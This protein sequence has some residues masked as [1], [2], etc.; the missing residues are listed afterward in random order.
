LYKLSP[1]DFAYIYEEC[2][3]CFYLKIKE[4]IS[5]PSTPFPGVF[6]ALNTRIQGSLLR[7]NLKKLSR[8]LPDCEVVNQEGFVESVVI[9]GTS[10]YIKG[11]YD[12]LCKNPDSTYTLVDL[13]ISIPDEEKI[14][15]YKTQ[16][17]AYKF[18]M[19]NPA[20]EKPIKITR[21]GLL[22]FYPDTL[23][24][25]NNTVDI[26]FPPK[27]MEIPADDKGFI[28]FIKE[29]DDLLNGPIPEENPDC[30][31]CKYTKSRLNYLQ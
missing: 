30:G 13:K 5:R 15:K 27:W 18:S 10:C 11:K 25:E 23:S 29:V 7:K 6:S 24:F 21:M 14:E 4:G 28:T 8:D 1:S 16:L 17:T 20:Q 2:K 12:L 9:H 31:F 19:E 26:N 22:I 3:H